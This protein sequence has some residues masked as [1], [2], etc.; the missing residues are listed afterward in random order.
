MRGVY[1]FK[2]CVVPNIGA[3]TE[4][5]ISC[6]ATAGSAQHRIRFTT[7]FEIR[8][9]FIMVV[10]LIMALSPSFGFL[11]REDKSSCLWMLALALCYI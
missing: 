7:D 9:S 4:L 6:H 5:L 1:W 2:I 11:F 10:L 3:K 8:A